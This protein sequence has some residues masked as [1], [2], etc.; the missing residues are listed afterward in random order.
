MRNPIVNFLLL[1]ILLLETACLAQH[2]DGPPKT[3]AART[4]T[5]KHGLI[6]KGVKID[7]LSVERTDSIGWVF[8]QGGPTGDFSISKT[9]ITF[10]QYDEFCE[11]S[12]YPKPDDNGWGR[13]KRP[14]I[15]VNLSDAHAFCTWLS[16]KTGENIQLPDEHEWEFAAQGGKKGGGFVYSGNNKPDGVAW[17]AGNSV[18]KTHDV[19]SKQPNELG[20]YD[21]SGNVWEWCG[22]SGAIRGGC[23]HDKD[24]YCRISN[25]FDNDPAVRSIYIGFRIV[26]K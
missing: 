15:N 8:V 12:G 6:E 9:E 3:T 1:A 4:D 25:R 5:V 24:K 16:A 17:Y 18:L 7:S 22:N 14:V 11:A 19:A 10:A 26:K 21:M 23:W 20:I 13:G 2:S